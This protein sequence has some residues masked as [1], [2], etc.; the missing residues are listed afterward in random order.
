[1]HRLN[2]LV[3][4]AG[5][6]LVAIR[7]GLWSTGCPGDIANILVTESHSYRDRRAFVRDDDV[8]PARSAAPR[9]HRLTSGTESSVVVMPSATHN[10]QIA[11]R[12]T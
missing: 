3:D 7:P 11:S 1:M 4:L 5:D 6:R 8:C 10:N 9:W 12:Q 2:Q